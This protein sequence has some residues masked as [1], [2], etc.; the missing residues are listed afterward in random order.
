MLSLS[1]SLPGIPQ[2]L[3]EE[4]N[5]STKLYSVSLSFVRMSLCL[6]SSSSV[7]IS[8]PDCNCTGSSYYCF[9]YKS[10]MADKL[11]KII[12]REGERELGRNIHVHRIHHLNARSD[13]IFSFFFLLLLLLLYYLFFSMQCDTYVLCDVKNPVRYDEIRIRQWD[14]CLLF[15]MPYLHVC[16]IYHIF[17]VHILVFCCSSFWFSLEKECN[18]LK[19]R[20]KNLWIRIQICIDGLKKFT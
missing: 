13:F 8:F 6:S 4:N 3:S 15:L 19:K 14:S 11:T 12:V 16:I 20:E 1:L 7:C 2:Y 5:F 9:T 18:R 10:F 17:W